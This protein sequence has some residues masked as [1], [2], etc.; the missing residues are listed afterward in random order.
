M[1]DTNARCRGTR[2]SLPFMRLAICHSRAERSCHIPRSPNHDSSV[3]GWRDASHAKRQEVRVGPQG[4]FVSLRLAGGRRP[5]GRWRVAKVAAR[6]RE[7]NHGKKWHLRP[8]GRRAAAAL[9]G[10]GTPPGKPVAFRGRAVGANRI[11]I[12]FQGG[13]IPDVVSLEAAEGVLV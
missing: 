2:T 6:K 12:V 5:K 1:P 7:S 8:S 9:S 11:D 3:L 4:R 13:D 10:G